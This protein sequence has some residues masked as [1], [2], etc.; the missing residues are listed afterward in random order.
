[1]SLSLLK[2]CESFGLTVADVAR[3]ADLDPK[4]LYKVAKGERGFS[5]ET[6][7]AIEAATKGVVTPSDLNKARMDWLAAN[8]DAA[9]KKKPEAGKKAPKR[10]FVRAEE[11]VA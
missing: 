5:P 7:A 10:P 3:E 9:R 2:Y 6:A 11:P 8:P 4:W 1:M